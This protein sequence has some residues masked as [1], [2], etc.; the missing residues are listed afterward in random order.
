M[1]NDDSVTKQMLQGHLKATEEEDD[2]GTVTVTEAL[3]LHPY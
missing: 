3:V 2:P 1:W